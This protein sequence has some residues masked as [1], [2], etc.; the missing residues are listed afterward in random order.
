[1]SSA[2]EGSP[3]IYREKEVKVK[4]E[5]K[6]R[7]AACVEVGVCFSSIEIKAEE[8]QLNERL[9]YKFLLYTSDGFYG[10]RTRFG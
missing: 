8:K 5:V 2:V 7:R 1:M 3:C 10:K 6:N 4:I 9:T